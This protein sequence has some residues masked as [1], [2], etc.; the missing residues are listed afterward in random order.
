VKELTPEEKA[1]QEVKDEIKVRWLLRL[2]QH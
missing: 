1:R 2:L